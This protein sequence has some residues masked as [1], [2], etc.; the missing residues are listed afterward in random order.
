MTFSQAILPEFDQEM[1]HTRKTLERVPE[2]KYDWKPHP[3]SMTM[4]RLAGHLAQLPHWAVETIRREELDV[5]P[6][7]SEPPKP[8][9]AASND[10][11]LAEF[12]KNVAEA[13]GLLAN[14]TDEE[15]A[16]PWSLLVG[17]KA[18]MTMPRA[19]VI[20]GVVMNHM[21]HHRAQLGVYLRLND[22]A[23]PGMYGPSADESF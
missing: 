1:T 10:A 17:G 21:I 9:L 13:R 11:L 4:M 3:K 2:D 5:M 18:V 19:A 12:D 22:V 20:R 23:V 14:V 16:K 8:F 15:I 6:P 7:G